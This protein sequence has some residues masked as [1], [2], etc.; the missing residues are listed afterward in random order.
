MT[1]VGSAT[2]TAGQET[3]SPTPAVG[4]TGDGSA[5]P[6]AAPK[7]SFPVRAFMEVPRHRL[8]HHHLRRQPRRLPHKL[9]HCRGQPD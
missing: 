3:R 6:G 4:A 5:A 8:A 1:D 2:A 7:A 9:L